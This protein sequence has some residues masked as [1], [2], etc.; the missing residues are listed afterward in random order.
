MEVIAAVEITVGQTEVEVYQ[1]AVAIVPAETIVL[2]GVIVLAGAIV[3]A[4][5]IV[6]VEPSKMSTA[7]A[8]HQ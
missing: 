3:L 7:L 4:G 1:V 2:A 6:L 8:V 5:V